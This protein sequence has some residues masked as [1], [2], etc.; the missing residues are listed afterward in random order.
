MDSHGSKFGSIG[1]SHS[2][3]NYRNSQPRVAENVIYIFFCFVIFKKYSNHTK[4]DYNEDDNVEN[5]DDRYDSGYTKKSFASKIFSDVGNKVDNDNGTLA[6]S[7]YEVK[8]M[9]KEKTP[10]K[11]EVLD[12]IDFLS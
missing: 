12:D 11:K 9:K 7:H 8:D 10:P 2:S 5:F 6:E 4:V 1:T 3:G